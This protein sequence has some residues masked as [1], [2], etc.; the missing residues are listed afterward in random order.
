VDGTFSFARAFF[1]FFSFVFFSPSL[2]RSKGIRRVQKS[3]ELLGQ[4]RNLVPRAGQL[5]MAKHLRQ[6]K[7]DE[8]I[9]HRQTGE[10][11]RASV[12]DRRERDEGIGHRQG[13]G[14]EGIGHR[15][16][17]KKKGEGARASVIDRRGKGKRGKGIG[18]GTSHCMT[19]LP[20]HSPPW[21]GQIFYI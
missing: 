19:C 5:S 10:V 2:C 11:A 7:R 20:F 13:R 17:E 18:Y 4:R 9:G 21:K 14:G 8:G 15:Q 16:T 6:K 3:H 12:I 1:L